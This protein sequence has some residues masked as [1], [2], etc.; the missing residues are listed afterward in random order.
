VDPTRF[1]RAGFAGSAALALALGP[2]FACTST[3]IINNY[4]VTPD[5]AT[6]GGGSGHGLLPDGAVVEC[7]QFVDDAGVPLAAY[8]FGTCCDGVPV[9]GTCAGS[10]AK[11]TTCVLCTSVQGGIPDAGPGP[12]CK[13]GSACPYYPS[14]GTD[15]AWTPSVPNPEGTCYQ[16]CVNAGFS[17]CSCLFR[18]GECFCFP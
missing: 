6:Q 7:S 4:G 5:G 17:E 16:A 3:T 12:L 14:F 13:R 18:T 11:Q 2:F 9:E 10:G 8:P 1:R 15:A